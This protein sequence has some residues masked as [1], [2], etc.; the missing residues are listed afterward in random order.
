MRG[1]SHSIYREIRRNSKPDGR[2]NPWWAHNEALLRPDSAP[3]EEKICAGADLRTLIR[4][5][6]TEKWSPPQIARFLAGTHRAT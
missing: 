5:K 6:L 4:A 3:Q 1:R 2:Y